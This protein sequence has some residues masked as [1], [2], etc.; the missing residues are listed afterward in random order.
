MRHEAG[1]L[2]PIVVR[3][4]TFVRLYISSFLLGCAALLT[5]AAVSRTPGSAASQAI[6][7]V[8][9]AGIAIGCLIL[10]IRETKS[11]FLEVSSN[12]VTVRNMFRTTRIAAGDIVDVDAL[13]DWHVYILTPVIELKAHRT[14]RLSDFGSTTWTYRKRPEACDCGR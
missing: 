9:F 3:S 14:Y 6:G 5:W 8:F 1:E 7:H 10:G 11:G 13:P 12:C 2:D 4:S